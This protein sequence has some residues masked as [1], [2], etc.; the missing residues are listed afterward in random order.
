[1]EGHQQ[2]SGFKKG[3]KTLKILS[4]SFCVLWG[5]LAT[6]STAWGG[7]AINKNNL[8]A[9][10]F[11]IL[12]RNAATDHAD[13]VSYNP[14][15]TTKLD[16][17]FYANASIQ[18]F[19]K[20]EYS[21]EFGGQTYE[22]TE[23]SLIP[24]FYSIYKKDRFAAFFSLNT[25]VGG[26][27]VDYEQGNFV[28]YQVG[29]LRSVINSLYWSAATGTSTAY[30][31]DSHQICAES[32]GIGY[33]LGGAYQINNMLSLSLGIRY[34]DAEMEM[35]GGA[36]LRQATANGLAP[37]TMT[38]NIALEADASGWGGIIG[39]DIFPTEKMTIGLKYE[40]RTKLEYGYKVKEGADILS[41][42]SDPVRNGDRKR[43]DLPAMFGAGI[44]YQ[45]TPAF[46]A[47]VGL[48]YYFN[49]SADI[50]G[51]TLRN[52]PDGDGQGLEDK[53]DDS[54][55]IGIGVEYAFSDRVKGSIG[56][57][58]TSVGV[59]PKYSSKFLPDLDAHTVAAGIEWNVIKNLDL[60]FAL[61]NVFYMSE[62][63]TD[64]SLAPLG[65]PDIHLTYEKNI[66]FVA[67]G[68]QYKFF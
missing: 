14:A 43:D 25:P 11:R 33:T 50:G 59:D 44:S 4:F 20:K 32:Y 16:D 3:E 38:E 2:F 65:E 31:L 61:G 5:L 12:T 21:N 9:E 57:L 34:I 53:I 68:I 18:D 41:S 67:L 17:G 49:Q 27:K 35:E 42:I 63:Y 51:T 64:N 7:G 19:I 66:P 8:S 10:Y 37:S 46:R 48:T 28:T 40:T 55:E 6:L 15:G 56:Y 13:I 30:T 23:G 1:M 54:Y 29:K 22:S 60:T 26:G 36:T 24:A 45:F 62:N 52:N 39:L 47:E 58:F